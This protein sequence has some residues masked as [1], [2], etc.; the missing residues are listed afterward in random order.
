MH[1]YQFQFFFEK[2]YQFVRLK[3]LKVHSYQLGL[4][5]NPLQLEDIWEL[6]CLEQNKSRRLFLKKQ[7]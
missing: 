2:L 5:H 3:L 7:K 6:D 4:S 1:K